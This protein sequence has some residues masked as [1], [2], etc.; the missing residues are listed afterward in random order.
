MRSTFLDIFK[1]FLKVWDE[2]L[3]FKLKTFDVVGNL[4]KLLENYLTDRQQGVVLN[5]QTSL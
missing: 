3:I 4:V 1:Q 2:G 5:G